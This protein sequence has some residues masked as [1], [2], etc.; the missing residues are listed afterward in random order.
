MMINILGTEYEIK[1]MSESQDPKLK[2]NY[3]YF[4][5]SV[6][7]IIVCD[8]LGLEAQDDSFANIDVFRKKLI[9]HEIIHAM[10]YESGLY[11]QCEYAMNEELVDW[12]ALQFDKMKEIFETI[13]MTEGGR[14]IKC[15]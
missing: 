9:R 1:I 14:W 12:I 5:P 8:M 7:Q 4:D 6:K 10:F 13:D 15:R 11:D 3:S 2:E